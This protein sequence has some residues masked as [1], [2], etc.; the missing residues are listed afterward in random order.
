ME[1]MPASLQSWHK[2]LQ[3]PGIGA[4]YSLNAVSHPKAVSVVLMR[5]MASLVIF[6]DKFL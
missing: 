1:F 3:H 5:V 6:R 4:A 2:R